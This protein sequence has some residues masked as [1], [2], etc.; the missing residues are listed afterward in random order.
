MIVKKFFSLI[1]LDLQLSKVMVALGWTKDALLD[2]VEIIDLTS[3]KNACNRLPKFPYPV[4]DAIAAVTNTGKPI[5]CGGRFPSY[6]DTCWAFENGDW[7]PF[8]SL[9]VESSNFAITRSPIANSSIDLVLTGGDKNSTKNKPLHLNRIDVLINNNWVSTKLSLPSKI[10]YHCM[11]LNSDSTLYII[12]GLGENS[13]FKETHSFSIED[14]TWRPKPAL[15]FARSGHA[16]S[17]LPFT[18]G[19]NKQ[20]IIVAGGADSIGKPLSSVE[21]LDDGADEWRT[22]PELP[23]P[24]AGSTMVKHPDGGVVLIGGSSNGTY[25]HTLYYLPHAGKS[26]QW[27][28]LPQKLRTGRDYHAVALVPDDIMT[29]C[30]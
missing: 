8:S 14:N 21:I 28:Q 10:A 12:G 13:E 26:A 11:L 27:E 1:Y 3:E 24:I 17:T 23:I 16:C 30:Y 20:S 7:Q 9:T 29:S 2:T 19:S 22:G 25:L 5:I 4:S 15:K 18:R 6:R